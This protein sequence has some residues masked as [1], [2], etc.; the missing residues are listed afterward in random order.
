MNR[1]TLFLLI[2]FLHLSAFS[3]SNHLSPVPKVPDEGYQS[4]SHPADSASSKNTKVA[5]N[6]IMPDFQHLTVDG[7]ISGRVAVGDIDNDGYND[8]IVHT[9]GSCRGFHPDGNLYWYKYPEWEKHVVQSNRKFF[10][11]EIVAF[12]LDNDGDTDIIA[13]IGQSTTVKACEGADRRFYGEIYWYENVDGEGTEWKEHRIGLVDNLSEVKDIHIHDMDNDGKVDIAV[14]AS[15]NIVVF[16]QDDISNWVKHMTSIAKREG[17]Y[18]A[19][20]D[21]DSYM[22]FVANG[23][24]L[25]NPGDRSDEWSRYNID[26]LWYS[27]PTVDPP[28]NDKWRNNAVRVVSADFDGDGTKDLVFSHS[29]HKGF[30]VTWYK[31]IGD[32]INQQ[33][34]A[35][36]KHEIGIVDFAH[37]LQVA[38]F[39][40]NG[41]MDVMAG[42]TVWKGMLEG[43]YN[44]EA[45]DLVIFLNDGAGNFTRHQIDN[46]HIYAGIVGDID[47]D[48]DMDIIGPRCWADDDTFEGDVTSI[49]IW[50]NLI[51]HNEKQELDQWTYKEVYNN[52][53]RYDNSQ[54]GDAFL[55]GLD[56]GDVNGDGI[57]DLVAG[58]ELH[59]APGKDISTEWTTIN[60]PEPETMDAALF[61]DVNKDSKPEIIGFDLMASGSI[62]WL[63]AANQEGTNWQ[64]HQITLSPAIPVPS[65]RNPQGY[66]IAQMMKNGEPVIVIEAGDNATNDNGIFV[67]EIEYPSTTWTTHKISEVSVGGNGLAVGDID[68]DGN[69]DVFTGFKDIARHKLDREPGPFPIYWLKNPGK[70]NRPWK[71]IQVDVFP[72]EHMPD[73]FAIAD[74]DNDGMNDLIVSE[75]NYPITGGLAAY[76]YKT[77][78]NPEVQSNWG[79]KQLIIDNGESFN[80]MDVLDM[81]G[82]GDNDVVI[83]DMGLSKDGNLYI[84]ENINNGDFIIHKIHENVESHGLKAG[85]IDGDGDMDIVAIAWRKPVYQTVRLWINEFIKK[86]M[87][88]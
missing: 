71:A 77:P 1:I 37:T 17:S 61:Y 14:R 64:S 62:Y 47:N 75:E 7:D 21:G 65:H 58:R 8:V 68:G 79:E 19:D 23:F 26:E 67:I 33:T 29:E 59:I 45:G 69:L 44:P 48:G 87:M 56:F 5:G 82:D 6:Q 51:I 73:R 40:M 46:K 49:D 70:F 24:W 83:A 20:I 72:Q 57:L 86:K 84:A 10:G 22:D 80:S 32:P 15:E 30:N 55:F 50:R 78:E 12:D 52:R 39:D 88:K 42:A 85:D 2:A 53:K 13:P 60:L 41:T 38:D 35:W 31:K 3:Y 25:R 9:W 74:I 16:Y 81:D 4:I 43:D 11:D 66:A 18:L 36:E 27:G 28:V 34:A 76:W 54:R 63:E